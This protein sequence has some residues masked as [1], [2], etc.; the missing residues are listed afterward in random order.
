[1][2]GK[3]QLATFQQTVW[4][5]YRVHGRHSLPWRAPEPDGSFDPYKILVSELMLQQTQVNRVIP[6]FTAFIDT[7]PTV[8]AL[9]AASLGDVLTAWNGLGYNRRAKFLWQSARMIMKD[10]AGRFPDTLGA[11]VRLPG[12]GPNTAGA[13]LAYAYGQPAVF[14]ETNIRTVFIHHFFRE[15]GDVP[16]SEIREL[17]GQ[18]LPERDMVRDWYAALMDYGTHLK[19]TVGNLNKLSDQYTKQSRFDGSRRQIR[20]RIIRELTAGSRHLEEL[21]SAIPDDRLR[22]VLQTLLSEQ[23]LSQDG[24]EYRLA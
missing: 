1:M 7:F 6:K 17:V 19:Q 14:I 16:D 18:T 11:L 15:R 8:E 9:A 2:V 12:V 24:D 4:E 22:S 3:T 20:G 10:M 23:L 13:I 21:Q 5:Y